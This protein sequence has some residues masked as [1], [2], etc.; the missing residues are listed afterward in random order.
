VVTVITWIV[1]GLVP[2]LWIVEL[3]GPDWLNLILRGTWVVLA[4]GTVLGGG[5][6]WWRRRRAAGTGRARR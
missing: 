4:V 1:L 3:T 5:W 2:V 6:V